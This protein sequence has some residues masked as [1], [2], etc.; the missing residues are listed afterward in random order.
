MK[1][2]EWLVISSLV[3]IGLVCLTFSATALLDTHSIQPYLHMLVQICL[4]TGFPVLIVGLVYLI[5]S[6]KR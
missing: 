4:W 3:A 5:W 1:W 2:I 6:W